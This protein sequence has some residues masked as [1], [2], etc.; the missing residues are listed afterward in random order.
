MTIRQLSLFLQE[1]A[2]LMISVPSLRVTAC[3]ALSESS[4]TKISNTKVLPQQVR[5]ERLNSNEG[6]LQLVSQRKYGFFSVTCCEVVD[7]IHSD[8]REE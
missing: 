6:K 4:V 3:L 1:T 8:V 7:D 5:Q 2:Q